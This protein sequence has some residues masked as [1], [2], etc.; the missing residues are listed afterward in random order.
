MF[1]EWIEKNRNY[2]VTINEYINTDGVTNLYKDDKFLLTRNENLQSIMFGATSTELCL[3]FPNDEGVGFVNPID[4]F[5]ENFFIYGFHLIENCDKMYKTELL[6]VTVF[7]TKKEGKKDI[8]YWPPI[9]GFGD[10]NYY[11]D[12]EKCILEEQM[13]D[14]YLNLPKEMWDTFYKDVEQ[15]RK[16]EKK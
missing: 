5:L 4:E 2:S 14:T 11:I 13:N 15:Q 10:D 8:R 9:Q 1:K 16:L 12:L 7:K 6:G 3:A